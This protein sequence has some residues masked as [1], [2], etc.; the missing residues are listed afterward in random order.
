[1]YIQQYEGFNQIYFIIIIINFIREKFYNFIYI[2]LFSFLFFPWQLKY[3]EVVFMFSTSLLKE[4][5]K[6]R[7]TIIGKILDSSNAIRI[8]NIDA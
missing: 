4:K 3:L 8:R 5:F 7:K 2:N 1:M 6:F